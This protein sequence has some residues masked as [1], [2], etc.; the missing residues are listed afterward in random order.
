[1]AGRQDQRLGTSP[2]FL[3][4]LLPLRCNLKECTCR[5]VPTVTCSVWL[6]WG[7]FKLVDKARRWGPPK[8]WGLVLHSAAL[9]LHRF[10]KAQSGAVL[11]SE[12]IN[13]RTIFLSGLTCYSQQALACCTLE[14]TPAPK[15]DWESL[16]KSRKFTSCPVSPIPWLWKAAVHPEW[17][18][19]FLRQI[20]YCGVKKL[21]SEHSSLCVTSS[22][23]VGKNKPVHF[24]TLFSSGTKLV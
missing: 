8:L 24:L 10:S 1:M 19:W 11:L 4:F 20:C 6:R 5:S 7:F 23:S 21:K 2:T 13:P 14:W 16:Y 22:V 3:L 18:S 9:I 15:G 17:V 12:Q